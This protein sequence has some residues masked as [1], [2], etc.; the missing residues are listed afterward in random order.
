MTKRH[1]SVFELVL[2]AILLGAFEALY[3]I[4]PGGNNAIHS[5][6]IL[7]A[8]LPLAMY[9]ICCG[10]KKAALVVLAGIGLSAI[11]LQPMILFSYAIPALIIGLLSGIVILNLKK[12]AAILSMSVL[13]LL[14]NCFEIYLAY[15]FLGI[16]FSET[17]AA[18]ID[19]TMSLISAYIKAE[20]VIL[21]IED[22]L[23]C[24]VPVA[25][26][27]GAFGK[28]VLF[29]IVIDYLLQS[30]YFSKFCKHGKKGQQ[31]SERFSNAVTWGYLSVLLVQLL[32]TLIFLCGLVEY[33]FFF[34]AI[35][36]F[37][38]VCAVIYLYHYYSKH[39]RHASL[40]QNERM[41]R[42]AFLLLLFPLTMFATPILELVRS[43]QN[44]NTP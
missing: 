38:A 43:N 34:P 9:T 20:S 17:Y 41:F 32:T 8:C 5:L 24:C 44:S 1:K 2:G 42:S 7:V 37:T 30:K 12:P 19:K 40:P 22:F 14:Q 3:I 33:H 31:T 28:G 23:L 21:F 26:I 25:L 18:V 4:V 35:T 36:A 10:Y 39:I 15:L 27:I 16:R 6:L 13:H 11:L 29:S